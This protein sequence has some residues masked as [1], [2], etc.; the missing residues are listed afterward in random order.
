MTNKEI[1]IKATKK[2]IK[3]GWNNYNS[4]TG[5]STIN[6]KK[7]YDGYDVI[8]SGLL[9]YNGGQWEDSDYIS[10]RDIIFDIDFAK[11]FWGEEKWEEKIDFISV[12]PEGD[13]C[14][15]AIIDVQDFVKHF[16][17]EQL[18]MLF[19][20]KPHKIGKHTYL[21]KVTYYKQKEDWQYH[22][23]QM[24]LEKEPLKYLEKFL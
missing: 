2:A 1:L 24:V 8:K 14:F 9:F 10:I 23:Q 19:D 22:L 13:N 17:Q 3:N 20:K 12:K 18:N 21:G 7:L 16:S 4:V 15:L 11:A 6:G 5:L